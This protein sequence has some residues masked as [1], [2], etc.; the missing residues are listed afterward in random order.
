MPVT[1]N[2]TTHILI[3]GAKGVGKTTLLKS[4]SLQNKFEIIVFSD[5]L[6][7]HPK[8]IFKKN[9]LRLTV[10]ERDSLR[11]IVALMVLYH[12]RLVCPRQML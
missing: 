8:E 6:K 7:S 9:F 2:N 11:E 4:I 5:L 3:G 12:S 1:V 10:S